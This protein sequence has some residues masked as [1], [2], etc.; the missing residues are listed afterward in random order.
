MPKTV[1]F[2]VDC[3]IPFM[4]LCHPF[5]ISRE[6]VTPKRYELFDLIFIKKT[7]KGI[8]KWIQNPI[9]KRA[10]TGLIRLNKLTFTVS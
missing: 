10:A 9:K 3:R 7:G 1:G 4:S 5:A 6:I 2:T 8:I